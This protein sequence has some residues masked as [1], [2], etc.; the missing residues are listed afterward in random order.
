MEEFSV[1]FVPIQYDPQEDYFPTERPLVYIVSIQLLGRPFGLTDTL[2]ST[3]R[4][5]FRS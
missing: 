2:E 1:P 5:A 4:S 3:T